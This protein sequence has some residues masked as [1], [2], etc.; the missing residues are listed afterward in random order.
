MNAVKEIRK[1]S[2]FI[3]IL[4]SLV[5]FALSCI[6]PFEPDYKGEEDDLLVVDGS[7]IKGF[8]TQVVNITRSSSIT[9]SEY[10]PVEN[11]HVTISDDAGNEFIFAEESQ[12][13]YT[14]H[15]EDALLNFDTRYKLVFSTPSGENYESGY[16]TLLRTAPVDSI[17]RFKELYYNPDSAKYTNGLQFYLDL[18]APDDAARYYRWQ[19]EETWEIRAWYKIYGMYDGNTITLDIH[20]WPSDSLFYCWNTKMATG[21]YTYSTNNLSHNILKKVPLHFKPYYSP[22]LTIKYCATVRQFALNEDAYYYWHHKEIELNESGQIYTT[23]PNQVKS[24]ISNVNNPDEKV[25]G[26][27]WASSCTFKHAFEENPFIRNPIGP[28]SCDSYGICTDG[29][30]QELINMLNDL[31]K[32]YKD[33]GKFPDPPVYITFWINLSGESC[34]YLS[35]DECIDCRVMGG[36]NHK[37]DYWGWH[38][39]DIDW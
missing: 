9:Q 7:L 36:T 5:L 30:E 6:S 19:I 31:I 16:Q 38:M 18:D 27:F 14:A 21:I 8:D 25:L 32:F 13:K 20:G 10:K 11:C 23:Q 26:F 34:A 33:V 37:P 1:Y 4:L 2:R 24:N 39:S 28:E 15:I 17:Y 12:G 3:L 29:S 22:D 35:I